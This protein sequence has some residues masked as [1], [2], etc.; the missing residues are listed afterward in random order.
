MKGSVS[1]VLLSSQSFSVQS[2]AGQ[3][4]PESKGRAEEQGNCL[5]P[6]MGRKYI[7]I[8]KH[9]AQIASRKSSKTAPEDPILYPPATAQM[10]AKQTVDNTS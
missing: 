5:L 8:H 4:S 1:G 7:H 9:M 10:S 6:E 3:K 2:T